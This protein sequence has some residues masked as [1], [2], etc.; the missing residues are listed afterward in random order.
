MIKL[1]GRA[2]LGR[3]SGPDQSEN[4]QGAYFCAA[5]ERALTAES[6]TG[7]IERFFALSGYVLS[8][9]FAGEPL[10]DS[11]TPALAHLEVP[12]TSRPDAV[13]HIWD[14]ESTGTDMLSPPCSHGC[15]TSRG[16]IWTMGSRRYKSAYLWSEYA[17][18]LFDTIEATGVYWTP[19]SATLPYWAKASPLR[20][21][22][23][24][25]AETRGCQLVH[26]A[27]VGCEGR[28]M[29]ITGKGGLGKSTTALS[30][31]NNGLDYI[32]DDYVL[33]QLD[34]VPTVH[35]LY[36]TAKLNQNQ[37][38]QFPQLAGLATT[39]GSEKDKAVINLYPQMKEQIAR[40]QPLQA[41]VTPQ[42][43][44][45]PQTELAT[46][47]AV[48]MQRATSFTT[49]SQLPHASQHTYHFIYR[50][51]RR[52]PASELILGT[53]LNAI[54][55]VID[56][57]LKSS[58]PEI[59]TPWIE[60][61]S[62]ELSSRPL[63]SIIM[64]VDR[65]PQFLPEAV[66]SVL[67]Q[68]YPAIEIIV[69]HNGSSDTIEGAPHRLPID[70]RFLKHHDARRAA[71]LNRGIREASGRFI[72]FLDGDDLWPEGNLQIMLAP[73]LE[74]ES[75]DVVQGFGR[76][77][78][79]G[80]AIGSDAESSEE[81]P[82]CP[83]AAIYR[84]EAFQKVGLFDQEL[85]FGEDGH[86]HR[87]ARHLGLKIQQVKGV[88]LIQRHETD[89]SRG[90]AVQ[91]LNALRAFKNALDQERARA[92]LDEKSAHPHFADR[93]RLRRTDARATRSN[94]LVNST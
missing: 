61:L 21:L 65:E 46:I 39:P 87:R 53:D 74:D 82:N 80:E 47:S 27:A 88:M 23:H 32:G 34:P 79:Q 77:R 43:S 75:Y 66:A 62:Q 2:K 24:W 48:A 94:P 68:N 9:K 64:P 59:N 89:T 93:E 55:G 30:C 58:G 71:A 73:L 76:K 92:V 57:L 13:F 84:R 18:S 60:T 67:A 33:V 25:W 69:V 72:T 37:M 54:P 19:T 38:A 85:A 50:L 12:P 52:L 35:S 42:I 44:N 5:L 40:S 20:C 78:K 45:R 6:S 91:E 56:D 22:F 7:I 10:A 83:T 4:E 1:Q 16:D 15:F 63:I 3:S 49:M 31:L 28:A 14:S 90:K 11:F 17:L 26:G 8:L 70:V 81:R 86:W 41:I 29:L 36:C 51:I